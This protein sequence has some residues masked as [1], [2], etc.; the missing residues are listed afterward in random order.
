ML[1]FSGVSSTEKSNQVILPGN[2]SRS[3]GRTLCTSTAHRFRAS[4][5]SLTSSGTYNIIVGSGRYI[6]AQIQAECILC[7]IRI[8]THLS[9]VFAVTPSTRA[10]NRSPAPV[11]PSSITHNA[12]QKPA[13]V[14]RRGV[15][16]FP[17][18]LPHSRM[19]PPSQKRSHRKLAPG[20]PA[21]PAI[22]LTD[23]SNAGNRYPGAI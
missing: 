17:M 6:P 9:A 2:V 11:V 5:L 20:N 16:V 8:R 18:E 19:L 1:E 3:F 23:A 22:R 7:R 12:G 15:T 4:S 14:Q 21:T 13:A 10:V